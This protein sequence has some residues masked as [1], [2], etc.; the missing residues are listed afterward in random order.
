MSTETKFETKTGQELYDESQL[1]KSNPTRKYIQK[2]MESAALNH[3]VANHEL[4]RIMHTSHRKFL[5]YPEPRELYMR[6]FDLGCNIGQDENIY[7]DYRI[8][9]LYIERRFNKIEAKI[10]ALEQKYQDLNPR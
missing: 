10:E 4:A 3:P 1:L 5:G 7:K 2:L 6:A 9:H 8:L